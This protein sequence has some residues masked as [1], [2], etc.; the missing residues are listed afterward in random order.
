MNQIYPIKQNIKKPLNSKHDL[1]ICLLLIFLSL[2]KYRIQRFCLSVSNHE[3]N[4][5]RASNVCFV[6]YHLVNK[7]QKNNSLKCASYN[8]MHI[9]FFLL[10]K[11][12]HAIIASILNDSDNAC[13]RL[14][15]KVISIL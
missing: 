9:I 7:C 2:H 14:L 3:N 1:L 4:K 13:V 8:F 12:I 15:L 6:S 11:A 5:S 10:F